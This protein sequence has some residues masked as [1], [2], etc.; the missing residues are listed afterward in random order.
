VTAKYVQ[1]D[2]HSLK[3]A[4][5]FVFLAFQER[6]RTKQER[7]RVNNAQKM[8]K[9]KTPVRR[10]AIL[11]R[12]VD[13]PWQEVH[14]APIVWPANLKKRQAPAKRFVPLVHRAITRTRQ[15]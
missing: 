15:T 1:L 5:H 9:A 14:R 10:N 7:H 12:K 2:M 13:L 3:T 4:R 8:K 6:T 11:V